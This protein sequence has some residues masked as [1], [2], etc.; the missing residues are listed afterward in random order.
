MTDLVKAG[1]IVTAAL[2]AIGADPVAGAGCTTHLPGKDQRRDQR[3]AGNI[4]GYC[5]PARK[6]SVREAGCQ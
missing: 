5:S 4:V 6:G 2:I 3:Q 1:A